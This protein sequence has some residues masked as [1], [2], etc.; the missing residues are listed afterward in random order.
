MRNVTLAAF[1]VALTLL[2]GCA[3]TS[4]DWDTGYE[5]TSQSADNS[6]LDN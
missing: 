6:V 5:T 1:V 4:T 3:H 2:S